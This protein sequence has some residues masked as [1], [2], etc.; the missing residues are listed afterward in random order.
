MMGLD[1]EWTYL[2]TNRKVYFT[3]LAPGEYT[4]MVKASN[5]SGLWNNEATRLTIEILPPFWA[6]SWAYLLYTALA[7][8]LVFYGIRAYHRK[9]EEKN[10]RKIKLLENEKEKE[11]YQAKIQF[12][13]N[14]AHEIRTPLTL[15]KGPL[16]SLVKR[17]DTPLA[18]SGNLKIME[19]N[20]DRLLELANQLLD[21]RK[22]E[23]EDF[24]LTFIQSDI[25]DLLEDTY[26][27]FQPAAE[28]SNVHFSLELPQHH[29]LAYVDSEA[30]IKILS[31]LFSNAIK[32]AE[33]TAGIRL[34]PV[35][36]KE[37]QTFT[38]VVNNDGPVIPNELR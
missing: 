17:S 9:T 19:K 36:S 10:H 31:N 33:S 3:E 37:D 38:I 27:R 23:T 35:Q 20:V 5:S 4:F 26:S 11:V 8:L 15:I 14:V 34:L 32:Y 2:K 18:A 24:S 6:S 25:S 30:L 29:L 7:A 21:F 1:K 28:Q 22:T 12:F 13:T 16:E